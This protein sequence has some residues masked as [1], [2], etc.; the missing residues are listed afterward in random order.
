MSATW[1]TRCAQ[2][3][4]SSTIAGCASSFWRE[5]NPGCFS[6]STAP[7]CFDATFRGLRLQASSRRRDTIPAPSRPASS[8]CTSASAGPTCKA[9]FQGLASSLTRSAFF[10][11]TRLRT[12]WGSSRTRARTTCAAD[13]GRC[14]HASATRRSASANTRNVHAPM[15]HFSTRE[16][17]WNASPSST[18]PSRRRGIFPGQLRARRAIAR[19]RGSLR[20]HIARR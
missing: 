10:W 7:T 15:R 16:C 20:A 6:M 12:S 8:F 2:R 17:R 11:D 3:A 18:T 13:A 14:T 4:T 19:G 5:G 9:R 1:P